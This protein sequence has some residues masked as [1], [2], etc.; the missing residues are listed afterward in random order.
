MPTVRRLLW[1]PCLLLVAY[2][3]TTCAIQLE[4][5]AG[6]LVRWSDYS[7]LAPPM[8][9]ALLP[10]RRTLTIGMTT[11]AASIAVY[12]YAVH[13]VSAGGRTVVIAAAALSLA[14][15]L[16]I[17]RTRLRLQ[18]RPASPA[19]QPTPSCAS[20]RSHSPT[21]RA[22]DSAVD[23]RPHSSAIHALPQPAAVQL[24]GCCGA[25]DGSTRPKAHWLDAIP[26]PGAR[27]A[28]VAGSVAKDGNPAP[29]IAADLRAAVRTLADLDLQP[30]EILTHLED[31]L[32]RLRPDSADGRHGDDTADTR[33]SCLYAVYD[34]F[35]ARCTLASAGHPAPTAVMPDGVITALGV[36]PGP[37]LG[38]GQPP[39][40]AAEIDLPE[41]SVLLL[42]ACTPQ[43][44]GPAAATASDTLP[45]T[46]ALTARTCLHAVCR[47]ALDAL[48]SARHGMHAGVLAART[49]TLD[50]NAV[51][52]W[53]LSA[54]AT[55][56][57]QARRH[58][59]A[60]LAAWGLQDDS[61]T[62]ELIASELVSNAIRHACPP[63]ELRLIRQE[64]GLTCEVSDG[65]NTSPHLRRARDLDE[66]GRGLFIV[67]QL[68]RRWGSRHHP[69]GKTIWAQQPQAAAA[70]GEA[71]L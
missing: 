25:G 18:H 11:L 44:P 51:A 16:V 55:A 52:R 38:Q 69:Y 17:C 35:A 27:V 37:P 8:A 67:A 34:P 2:L 24:A 64:T 65:S 12:G 71:G 1:R 40:E 49:R 53:S 43:P 68:T 70:A 57:S 41:G 10:V 50:G 59:S 61:P 14:V 6:G 54:D 20:P 21:H 30:E 36:P 9:A 60:K 46:T 45:P 48:L 56:V 39:A 33:A 22:P 31:F 19:Q 62:T 29:A 13:G 42:H 15:S 58:V 66:N 47:S 28:L 3:G 7:V 4:A 63:V 32:A 26:L 5:S 23:G